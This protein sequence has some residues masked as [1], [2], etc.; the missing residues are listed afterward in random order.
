MKIGIMRASLF[1]LL[2]LLSVAA[3]FHGPLASACTRTR[4]AAATRMVDDDGVE[5]KSVD[6]SSLESVD[7]SGAGKM[8]DGRDVEMKGI[9]DFEA[10]GRGIW[11]NGIGNLAWS[12]NKLLEKMMPKSEEPEGGDENSPDV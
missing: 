6:L 10:M 11:G 7:N 9:F 5:K 12:P 8:N 4:V 1:L 3:G 2:A